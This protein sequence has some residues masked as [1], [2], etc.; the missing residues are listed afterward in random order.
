MLFNLSQ[1]HP[2]ALILPILSKQSPFV[3]TKK[4]KEKKIIAFSAKISPD[5]IFIYLRRKKGEKRP[6]KM[7]EAEIKE[8]Y[9]IIRVKPKKENFDFTSLFSC[10]V[11]MQE[12]KNVYLI[13]YIHYILYLKSNMQSSVRC[14]YNL[15]SPTPS[16]K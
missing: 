7:L 11:L 8:H 6:Y 13:L 3:D 15:L 14:Q 16:P 5:F 2:V 12:K 10:L 1:K 9:T 4:V